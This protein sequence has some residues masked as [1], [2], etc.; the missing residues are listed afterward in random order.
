MKKHPRDPRR[1][2]AEERIRVVREMCLERRRPVSVTEL[3]EQSI[4]LTFRPRKPVSH[5]DANKLLAIL[6]SPAD[7]ARSENSVNHQVMATP[8]SSND[9][10]SGRTCNT[11]EHEDDTA[12]TMELGSPLLPSI[13]TARPGTRG[14]YTS[15]NDKCTGLTGATSTLQPQQ[16]P[17]ICIR[18]VK[19]VV[20][21]HDSARVAHCTDTKAAPPAEEWRV[22]TEAHH[23][24]QRSRTI[25]M[26]RNARASVEQIEQQP[27]LP[28]GILKGIID[29]VL[30]VEDIIDPHVESTTMQLMTF[31]CATA[32]GR[33]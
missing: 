1:I 2:S 19:S 4:P 28:R 12:C 25:Y 5:E 11:N 33:K 31:A 26:T 24:P 16:R 29:D 8:S 32:F 13:L 20:R 18:S 21:D 15:R 9:P 6:L 22:A 17:S 30:E 10:S 14:I 23:G 3:I 7:S 27:R